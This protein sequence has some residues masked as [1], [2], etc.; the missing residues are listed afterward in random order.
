ME[1]TQD[2]MTAA[3]I[4]YVHPWETWTITNIPGGTTYTIEENTSAVGGYVFEKAEE[5]DSDPANVVSGGTAEISGTIQSNHVTNVEFINR[6]LIAP[7]DI[8]IIKTDV[9]H[10][11]DAEP[12][13][14]PNAA[15]RLEKYKTSGY[16]ELDETWN[17]GGKM[18]VSDVNGTGTFLVQELPRGFYKLIETEF[19]AGYVQTARDPIFEVRENTTSGILEI[20]LL[21]MGQ[22]GT[23]A[24]VDGNNDGV[25]KIENRS[26]TV[27]NE[28]GAA[29]PS[30]GGPGTNHLY[31]LGL[32]FTGFTGAGL[33]MRKNRSKT[34]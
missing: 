13:H 9:E 27:G 33:L 2:H 3:A 23:V 25:V 14:L 6:K 1:E 30:A 10:L 12:V 31:L 7:I 8:T 21:E 22:D 19:P 28:P 15:F 4:I 5:K 32:T 17:N 16:Q 29:L 26:V 11:N 20:I 34:A 24:D 18:T